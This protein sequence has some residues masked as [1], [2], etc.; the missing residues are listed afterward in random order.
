MGY[1]QHKY[2]HIILM[3]FF[4]TCISINNQKNK[5]HV[6][7]HM[8]TKNMKK[9]A[10]QRLH[11]YL[12]GL[13]HNFLKFFFIPQAIQFGKISKNVNRCGRN[14]EFLPQYRHNCYIYVQ[15]LCLQMANN[16]KKDLGY[17]IWQLPNKEID[18]KCAPVIGP[19][20]LISRICQ[21]PSAIQH[22]LPEGI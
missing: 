3:I 8:Q 1:I 20:P 21:M 7:L 16:P 22:Q 4:F 11:N 14:S 19:G 2:I 18:S 10:K 13:N 17:S 12:K 15:Q 9:S 6:L 5:T